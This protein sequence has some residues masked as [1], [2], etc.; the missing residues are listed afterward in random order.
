GGTTVSFAEPMEL[1]GALLMQHGELE[2][3]TSASAVIGGLY[4]GAV[5]RA[6]CFAGFSVQGGVLRALVNGALAGPSITINATHKYALTTRL[7]SLTQ[8]RAQERFVS[9]VAGHGGGAVAGSVRV[10]LEVHDV[11]PAN[12]ATLQA[13]STVLYDAVI[14]ATPGF[15]TY[16]LMNVATMTGSVS[17]ARVQ[18]AVSTEV[19]STTPAQPTKTRLIGS[20]AEGAECIILGSQLVFFP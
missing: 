7:Y 12:V 4:S 17:F 14:A 1:G 9:S 18:R 13:P 8:Y 3:N 2:T 5:T 15:C 16:A 10:V 20:V 6:N 19:R 11:D